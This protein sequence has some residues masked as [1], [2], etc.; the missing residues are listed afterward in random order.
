MLLL[1]VWALSRKMRRAGQPVIATRSRSTDVQS[2]S[3]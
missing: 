2:G 1:F 3:L